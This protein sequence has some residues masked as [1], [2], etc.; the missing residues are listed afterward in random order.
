M[1]PN[2]Q[3]RI[4]I[5]GSMLAISAGVRCQLQKGIITTRTCESNA[6]TRRDGIIISKENNGKDTTSTA[7]QA[8][9][10]GSVKV[11]LT[12]RIS[13]FASRS[14]AGFL[15]KKAVSGLVTRACR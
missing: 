9:R 11:K 12:S 6:S 15:P 13:H 3:R 2:G 10:S 14:P 4:F 1:E 5:A 8:R 7:A